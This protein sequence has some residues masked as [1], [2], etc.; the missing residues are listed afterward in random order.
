MKRINLKDYYPFYKEDC[1]VEVPDELA[2]LMQVCEQQEKAYTERT[3]YHKA[4]Y[5]L[6]RDGGIGNSIRYVSMSPE[7]IYERRLTMK[8]LYAAISTL[9]ELQARRIYAHYFLG[10][11]RSEIAKV[12]GTKVPAIGKSIERGLKHIGKYLK[13]TTN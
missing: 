2:A 1:Y 8:E 7:E 6:E 5:S 12:E 3:R 4:Y 9:P 11:S 13:K 10:M